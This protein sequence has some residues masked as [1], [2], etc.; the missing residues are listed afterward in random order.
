MLAALE[1]VEAPTDDG[2]G[3]TGGTWMALADTDG[4]A[5]GLERV[6]VRLLEIASR[7]DDDPAIRRALMKLSDE[8]VKI[9]DE[10]KYY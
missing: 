1:C 3:Q 4:L 8:L 5:M 2:A 10:I 6:V 7:C 9:I